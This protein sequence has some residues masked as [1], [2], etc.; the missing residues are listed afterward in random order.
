MKQSPSAVNPPL[1]PALLGEFIGTSLLIVLGGGV[2]ATDVLLNKVSDKMMVTTAWG[3]AVELAVYVC[4]WLSGGHINPAVT[5]AL[6]AR[7]EFPGPRVLSYCAAQLAGAFVGTLIIY[8]D[9]GEDFRAFERHEHLVRGLMDGGKLV[10]KAAG[11]AGVFANYPAFDSVWRNVLSEFLGTAV[12]LDWGPCPDRP[13]E[14]RPRRLPGAVRPGRPRLGHQPL[15]GGPN[16]L[17]D[18]S[19][20]GTSVRESPPPSSAGD[21]PVFQFHGSYFWIPIFAPLTGGLAGAYLYD[22]A[23]HRH[24]PPKADPSTVGG[25]AP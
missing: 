13:E 23:I 22:L 6:A 24:L 18:Q 16:R 7:G 4:G 15:A 5:L 3:L 8:A 9:Y 10:G 11:A 20:R 14:R 1:R 19:H 2:V 25:I 17:R 12:L 21:R